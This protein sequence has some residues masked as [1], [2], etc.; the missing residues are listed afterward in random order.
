M[1]DFILTSLPFII[2][3]ISVA[4]IIVNSNKNKETYIS[5][6]MCLG[7]SFGLL[8]GTSFGNEH[9]GLFLSLGMLIGEAIGSFIIKNKLAN[10]NQ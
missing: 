9:I 4:V 10:I 6:G 3:G 8:L 5:E 1:K 2:I 7:M